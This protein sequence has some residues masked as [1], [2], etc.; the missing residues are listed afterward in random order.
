VSARALPPVEQE[1]ED[2]SRRTRKWRR[3]I[4]K[5]TPRIF[6]PASPIMV[7]WLKSSIATAIITVPCIE[8]PDLD[9]KLGQPGASA[10]IRRQGAYRLADFL[11]QG[12]PC[13]DDAGQVGVN[14]WFSLENAPDFA[15]PSSKTA[16]FQC[17]LGCVRISSGPFVIRAFLRRIII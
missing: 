6:S 12:W 2:I 7:L 1:R 15:P 8:I 3:F 11:A 16:V 14:L 9:Q 4:L 17:F 10:G 13:L 5:A